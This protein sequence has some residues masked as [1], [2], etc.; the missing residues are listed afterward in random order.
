[1]TTRFRAT[2]RHR[3]RATGARGETLVELLATVAVMGIA[4]V[5]IVFG[6][7]IAVKASGT[8]RKHGRLEALLRNGAEAITATP[9]YDTTGQYVTVL[10]GVP[11]TGNDQIGSALNH[12]LNT[13]AGPT[14]VDTGV[15][16]LTLTA[17]AGSSSKTLVI[18][19]R[20]PGVGSP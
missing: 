4:V 17:T 20:N 8:D 16:E 11:K 1:M 7:G 6:M 15:Q 19:K 18:V 10:S 2:R 9:A 3:R 13:S 14:T 12:Y 5:G